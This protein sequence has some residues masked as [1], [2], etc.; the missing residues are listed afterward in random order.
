MTLSSLGYVMI[1]ATDLPAWRRFGTEI[2][3]AMDTA[4]TPD[5][6]ALKIDE[7]PFR[8]LIE[9]GDTDQLATI[10]WEMA[11]RAAWEDLRERLSSEGMTVHSGT[12][13]GAARRRVTDFFSSRDPAGNAIEFYFG[14]TDCGD[15]FA[16]PA[17]V[18]GFV[19]DGMG[20]GHIVV[21]AAN[22]FDAT[23]EFYTSV[24]GLGDSDDLTM[25]PP[26][27]GAP[28][29][30]VRFMHADNPRHHSLALFNLPVPTGIVHI[31]L[32]M[33]Q[34]DDVGRC[35]DR[36]QAGGWSLMATLGRHCNDNML[37]FYVNGPANV[38]LEIGCEGLQLDWSS[39]EPTVSTVPDFWGHAYQFGS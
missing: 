8:L 24:L 23:H 31:M 36:A 12:A 29:M 22:A 33:R 3:G 14:R 21:S 28:E 37:S 6:V 20:L 2:I 34:L 27:E 26:A 39:F 13:D 10:G 4:A 1:S 30:R 7:H 11:S 35:Y 19:T 17:G 9:A 15:T 18:S 32:E 38:P 25:T 16:S 5:T